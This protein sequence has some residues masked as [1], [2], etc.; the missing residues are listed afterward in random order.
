MARKRSTFCL[1]GAFFKSYKPRIESNSKFCDHGPICVSII[2]VDV[3][4]YGWYIARA[5][6]MTQSPLYDIPLKNRR[7]S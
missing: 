2:C 3:I 7:D 1:L 5:R 6:Y 4:S